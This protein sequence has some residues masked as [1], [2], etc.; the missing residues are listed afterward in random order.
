MQTVQTIQKKETQT[1]EDFINFLSSLKS[2][3][4]MAIRIVRDPSSNDMNKRDNP[5]WN[6]DLRQ[7]RVEKHAELA[8]QVGTDYEIKVS[9]EGIRKGNEEKAFDFKAEKRTWGETINRSL[10]EHK[11]KLY[12]RSIL[13][14]SKSVQWIDKVTGN[15]VDVS[16]YLKERKESKKQAEIGLT[17]ENQVK[18]FNPKLSNIVAYKFGGK[19]IELTD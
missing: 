17:K 8:V 11:G 13:V 12:L 16:Q 4:F 14:K 10:V 18:Y 1:K 6:K 3:V 9:N 19:W 15:I 7:W 5:C 2:P